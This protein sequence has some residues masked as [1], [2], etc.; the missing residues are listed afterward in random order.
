MLK[1]WRKRKQ[2]EKDMQHYSQENMDKLIAEHRLVAASIAHLRNS[3]QYAKQQ[4]NH[5]G[6]SVDAA[7]ASMSA[8]K[9]ELEA[10]IDVLHEF[11][12]G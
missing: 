6:Q 2:K 8:R 1:W 3:G 10:Y 12:N 11:L 9:V 7:I 4:R 5:G